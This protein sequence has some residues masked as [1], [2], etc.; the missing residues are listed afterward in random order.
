MKRR[1]IRYSFL[2]LVL[3]A[4]RA[5]AT[6]TDAAAADK[7]TAAANTDTAVMR[8][9][10]LTHFEGVAN[11]DFLKM[12]AT[13]TGDYA[14][15]EDGKIWNIDSVFYNIQRHQPFTVKFTLTDFH[16]FADTRSGDG[17]YHSHADFVF[18]DSVRIGLDFIETATFR[19]T[20]AGWR[21][22]SIHV[23]SLDSPEVNFPSFYKRYDTVRYIPEHYRERMQL[24]A[25]E[26]ITRG[27]V[28]FLGNS[29]TEF[30]DWKRL[31]NDP[32]VLNRGIAGDNTFGMLDRLPE[33]I[34]RQPAKLFIEAGINDIGQ[35]VPVNMIVGNIHSLVEWIKVRSPA[36]RIYV[37]SVLPTNA[38]ANK[39]YPE[40]AGKNSIVRRVDRQLQDQAAVD[41]YTYVDLAGRVTGTSGELDSKF[42]RPDGLHLN[43]QGYQLLTRLIKQDL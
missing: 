8:H 38:Q 33:V 7:D 12:A 42:A 4:G 14:I 19:K 16:L 34:A 28:V 25:G 35:G 17:S 1:L 39:Q 43:G 10:I 32:S 37:I 9:L 31:L 26:P 6:V 29:I 2:F 41:G 3:A 5:Q 15:Y 13:C 22:H 18:H 11:K 24:F 30:G 21:I 20:A 40:V 27:G 23:T 36:T